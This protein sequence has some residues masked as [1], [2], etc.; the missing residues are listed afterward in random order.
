M[1]IAK[2]KCDEPAFHRLTN[3]LESGDAFSESELILLGPE[4]KCC[5]LERGHV[6][7][8]DKGVIWRAGSPELD[9]LLVPGDLREEV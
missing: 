3:F 4:A 5:F 8:D 7:I 2:R 9:R 6:K 1:E